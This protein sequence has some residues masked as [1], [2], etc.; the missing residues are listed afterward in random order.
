M[1]WMNMRGENRG[2]K[3]AVFICWVVLVVLQASFMELIDDEA[4]YW[5]TA[6]ELQWGY[7]HQP[8]M[9]DLFIRLGGLFFSGELGVRFGFIILH[10]L[11]LILIDRLI[12]PK[13]DMLMIVMVGSLLLLHVGGFWAVLDIPYLFFAALLLF[14][15]KKYLKKDSWVMASMM[16][17]TM[18]CIMYS[19]YH[20]I[21][22]ILSLLLAN[23]KLFKRPSYY[24]AGIV[25][26]LLFIPHLHWL[27][28]NDFVTVNY[29][30]FERSPVPFQ[31]DYPFLFLGAVILS[32]GPILGLFL[33]FPILKF[34]PDSDFERSL[35][36]V[37]LGLIIFFGLNSFRTR[38]EANWLIGC[39]LPL[40]ILGHKFLMQN[41]KLRKWV[42]YSFPISL[43]IAIALRV[44]LTFNLIPVDNELK[45]KLKEFHNNK[46]WVSA[47]E[48]KADGH[49]VVFYSSY[50]LPSKYLFYSKLK[51]A[52][53]IAHIYGPK[54]QFQ[55]DNFEKEFQYKKVLNVFGYPYQ[56]LDT[57]KTI[58]R[59]FYTRFIDPYCSF[60]TSKIDVDLNA[61]QWKAGTQVELPID[62]INGEQVDFT[63]KN[64]TQSYISYTFFKDGRQVNTVR[65]DV[66]A[67]EVAASNGDFPLPVKLPEKAGEYILN[68]SIWTDHLLPLHNTNRLKV[69]IVE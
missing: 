63:C 53:G 64:T 4:Y 10:L 9:V 34:E 18:A 23:L 17:L 44:I 43:A 11:T 51:N 58:N 37:F 66:K 2:F 59:T 21:I 65:T 67:T 54:S 24:F 27:Y 15:Y 56:G 42:Y 31:W 69:S 33:I 49:P 6:Q 30:L 57:L 40:L 22:I 55:L 46:E 29:H 12:E 60:A 3:L 1:N 41:S 19:K 38:I 45:L 32:T 16:G 61:V 13:D 47:I 36:Y 62:I 7:F 25:A 28:L 52:T 35:K 8:P 48:Q 50:Q 20:G 14:I 68:V 26:I 5:V 39:A